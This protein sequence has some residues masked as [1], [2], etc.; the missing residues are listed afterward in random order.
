MV[1]EISNIDTDINQTKA[2][3]LLAAGY[4][5]RDV[6]KQT[7]ISESCL[8]KWSK[9]PAF[10]QKLREAVAAS[11]DAAIAELCS[12]SREAAQELKRIIN[13]SDVPARTKINAIS[14]LLSNAEKAK[15]SLLE[16]RLETLENMINSSNGNP[17]NDPNQSEINATRTEDTE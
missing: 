7:G 15:T 1:N 9:Q 6:A 5:K 4:S 17:D 14:V 11:Y 12:G 8:Q 10:R 3:C 16:D 2:L 13:D